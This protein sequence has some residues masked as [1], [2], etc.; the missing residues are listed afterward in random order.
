MEDAGVCWWCG[1]AGD[2]AA[3]EE[4]ATLGDDDVDLQ[5]RW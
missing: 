2:A 3:D 1:G 4:E 5:K